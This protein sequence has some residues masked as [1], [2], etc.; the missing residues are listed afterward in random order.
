M[1]WKM[2]FWEVL[3]KPNELYDNVDLSPPN[4]I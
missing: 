4:P 2:A 1:T 3:R